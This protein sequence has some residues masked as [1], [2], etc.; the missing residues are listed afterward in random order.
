MNYA[1]ENSEP[2]WKPANPSWTTVERLRR[3]INSKRGLNLS[4]DRPANALDFSQAFDYSRGLPRSSQV[5]CGILRFLAGFM[6]ILGHDILDPTEEGLF[7]YSY[8]RFAA[9]FTFM[10]GYRAGYHAGSSH[11][12]SRRAFELRGESSCP[13]GRWYR[14]H[15]WRGIRCRTPLQPPTA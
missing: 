14:L 5:L 3:L 12:V 13:K 15:S 2:I 8:I 6:G 4:E 1:F 9:L 7:G 11:M 10:A